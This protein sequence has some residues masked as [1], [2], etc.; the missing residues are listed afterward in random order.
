MADLAKT[1]QLSNVFQ[2][3]TVLVVVIFSPV[4]SSLEANGGL[5]QIA[6]ESIMKM[7]TIFIGL[8]VL[9]FAFVCQHSAFIVAGSLDKPTRKRWCQVT[10][11]ALGLCVILEGACGVS[12]YLAFLE[13]TEGNLSQSLACKH[14]IRSKYIST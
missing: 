3:L 13:E 10:N 14:F 11:F 9:S 6:S 2:C 5:Q 4:S 8:G 1:S 7:D 12:G